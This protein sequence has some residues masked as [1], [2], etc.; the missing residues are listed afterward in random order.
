M[1]TGKFTPLAC[2]KNLTRYCFSWP[3]FHSYLWKKT[4]P[5]SIYRKQKS[6]FLH[7]SSSPDLWLQQSSPA[8]HCLPP[9]VAEARRKER[10]SAPSQLTNASGTNSRQ[11]HVSPP[12]PIPTYNRTATPPPP[13]PVPCSAG[14][15]GP[16]LRRSSWGR[17][18]CGQPPSPPKTH[19]TAAWSIAA[20]RDRPTCS[21]LA[22]PAEVVAACIRCED[23]SH[24]GL[25][26]VENRKR[27]GLRM[28]GKPSRMF[29]MATPFRVPWNILLKM[30]VC[31]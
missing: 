19:R 11:S 6:T 9:G 3:G 28:I 1:P 16:S 5:F 20:G 27:E 30:S 26:Q 4:L 18:W 13:P 2:G 10:I 22:E 12:S 23:F 17:P 14:T 15:S 25:G 29:S 24:R 7:P 21:W 31:F 8:V